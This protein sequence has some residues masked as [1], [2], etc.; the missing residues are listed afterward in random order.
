MTQPMVDEFEVGVQ[1]C[2]SFTPERLSLFSLAAYP[3]CGVPGC[4]ARTSW[5][6]CCTEWHHS[7]GLDACPTNKTTLQ[8]EP[9]SGLETSWED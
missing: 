1:P 5:C 8:P 6:S 7:G 9:R 2:G 4:T 3:L